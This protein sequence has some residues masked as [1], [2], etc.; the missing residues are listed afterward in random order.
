MTFL[1]GQVEDSFVIANEGQLRLAKGS[2]EEQL[3]SG[4]HFLGLGADEMILSERTQVF[5][6]VIVDGLEVEII[7]TV[8]NA[9]RGVGIKG[10]KLCV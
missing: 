4:V 5:G 8:T 3:L 10:G 7:S 1:D 2:G 9:L 6:L